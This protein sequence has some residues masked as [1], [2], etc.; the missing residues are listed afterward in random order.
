[1]PGDN[2]TRWTVTVSKDTDI[3]VRSLLARRGMKKGDLSRF[4]EEAVKWR[5]FD[6]TLAEARAEFAD[7]APEDAQDLI[8]EATDAVRRD[9]RETF[10]AAGK[11]P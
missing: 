10:A 3:A 8:N 11:E 1:M 4:I 9:M 2:A 5:V 7:L 6:Q